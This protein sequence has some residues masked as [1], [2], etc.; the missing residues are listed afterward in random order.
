MNLSH[1]QVAGPIDRLSVT[2]LLAL[3]PPGA[4]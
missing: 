2:L 1:R 4:T 3:G